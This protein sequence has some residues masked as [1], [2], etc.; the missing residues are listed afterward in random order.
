MDMIDTRTFR[1][2]DCHSM[3]ALLTKRL[4]ATVRGAVRGAGIAA[5]AWLLPGSACLAQVPTGIFAVAPNATQNTFLLPQP[6]VA[7]QVIFVAW[8]VVNPASGSYD[9]S[10]V[11]TAIAPWWAGGKKTALI[12][13]AVSDSQGSSA[14]P[15][16]VLEQLPPTVSCNYFTNVP[17]FTAPAF[18]SAYST[19]LAVLFAKYGSD[20]RIAYIRVGIGAG[21][22]TF[23]VCPAALE[24]S[25]GLTQAAWQ[26]YADGILAA[27]SLLLASVPVQVGLNCY[28]TPCPVNNPYRFPENL[29]A[30][31]AQYGMGIGHEAL[32]ESDLTAWNAGLGC[33]SN[34]C[35][36]FP[37]YPSEFHDLQFAEPTCANGDCPVGSPIQLLP[38]AADRGADVVEMLA[39]TDL[40]IAY[41]PNPGPYTLAYQQAIANFVSAVGAK[42]PTNRTGLHVP[43]R[44][45]RVTGAKAAIVPQDNPGFAMTQQDSSTFR[46]KILPR[47]TFT[48]LHSFN[49]ADGNAPEAAPIQGTDGNL[50]GTTLDDGA[51]GSGTVFTITPSGTLT[52]LYNFCSQGGASCTDGGFPN[53]LVQGVDGNFYGTTVFGGVNG[54]FGTIFK[55]TANGTLTTLY[56]FCPQRRYNI[57]KDGSNPHA[58]LIQ[59]AN[60]NFY[61]TTLE[62]GANGGGTVFK[63]TP[64]GAL[65]TLHSFCSQGG[66]GCTDGYQPEAGLLQATNGNFYGTTVFGG[67]NNTCYSGCGTVF[68]IT[69]S[70]ALT[71]LHSFNATDGYVPH[72]ALVQAANGMFYGTTLNGGTNG[73]GNVF[74]MAAS[75]TLTS[76]YGFCSQNNCTD[77]E[78]PN[79]LVQGSDGNFYGTTPLGGAA[80]G[81]TNANGCGTA[82][83]L[84]PS[85]RLTTLYNFCS[86]SACADGGYP[87]ATLL[88]DTNGTF[89]GTTYAGGAGGF[90]TV[91]S[92]SEGLG[93]FVETQPVSGAV[94]TAVTILGTNLTG[95]TNVTFNGTA[96]IFTVMSSSEITTT[97]PSGAHTGTVQ[98][99]TPGGTLSSNAPFTVLP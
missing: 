76:L 78:N 55:I 1:G 5:L 70:G 10:T 44:P 89:Y 23:P 37:E 39:A 51:N 21:G 6:N 54:S 56:S 95:A 13:W 15:S 83:R 74:K 7:G 68:K 3:R 66:A 20:P 61:G 36:L 71:T 62:G 38:F 57:C 90:G 85:G 24:A 12:V 94:G 75:G 96:A 63:I 25:Y 43:V 11:E 26:S 93:P 47:Q 16:Y 91:I 79:G 19:F 64:S 14:T 8:S 22:E 52:T 2:E 40:T 53:G 60:G 77:G 73:A 84:S 34:W 28:G 86:Q 35:A 81:C 17:D 48:T 4:K 18:A 80:A 33:D 88:Q 65:T 42:A 41:G 97:V 49:G 31:A 45:I 72:T 98:V 30:L 99:V 46:A 69:P 58:G 92:L 59:G 87:N 32:Q 67:A 82:F 50:Y 27:E 9:W 29:A